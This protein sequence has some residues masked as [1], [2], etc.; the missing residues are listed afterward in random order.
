MNSLEKWMILTP[1]QILH[2]NVGDLDKI[3]VATCFEWL[4]KVQKIAKSSH[5]AHNKHIRVGYWSLS[6][7]T[8]TWSQWCQK[9]SK[10]YL[11]D[12]GS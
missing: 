5:T 2:N 4:A 12:W 9:L 1:L 10:R 7:Y 11:T 8:V 6:E 3:I